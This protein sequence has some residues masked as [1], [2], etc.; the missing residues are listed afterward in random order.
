MSD[1]NMQ[2]RAGLK[3]AGELV[4]FVETQVLPGLDLSAEDFWRDAAG[5]FEKFVPIPTQMPI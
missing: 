5:I 3:I 1:A 4:D 2:D